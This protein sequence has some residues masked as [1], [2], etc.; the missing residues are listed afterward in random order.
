MPIFSIACCSNI[1]M[2]YYQHRKS[3]ITIASTLLIHTI[4]TSN[5]TYLEKLYYFLADLYAKLN[6]SMNSLRET[7]KSALQ[8][9]NLLGCSE[10]YIFKMQKN[11]EDAGY[12]NIIREIDQDN[13]NEKNIII[14]TLPEDVFQ[15]L[16][17]EPNRKGAEHL[18]AKQEPHQGYKRSHLD[19]SKMFISF[20]FLMRICFRRQDVYV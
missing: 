9:A 11:L 7:E 15:E 4:K 10:G 16:D 18:V 19:N 14:P 1:D 3:Y 12:F 6:E 5:L 20:N 2:I 8:W 17:Q 13:Q